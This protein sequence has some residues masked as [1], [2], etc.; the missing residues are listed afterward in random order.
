[1]PSHYKFI[2]SILISLFLIL[3]T[4]CSTIKDGPPNYHVNISKIPNAVPKPLPRSRY[5]NPTTYKVNGHRYHVLN[6]AE[7]YNKRGIASWYGSKFKGHLTSNREVYSPLAMTAASR[8]LPLP[9]FVRVTNLKNG[10]QV[11]VKVNDRGPFVANRIIDLSWAAAKKLRFA[12]KGTAL[13]QVTAI[14]PYHPNSLP[15]VRLAKHP[16]LYL[17]LG[18]FRNFANAKHLMERITKLTNRHVRINNSDYEHS[19]IYRVQIGP[20]IGV[21]ESD[22]LQNK[23]GE[24]GLGHAITVIG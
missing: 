14:N 3:L 11:I 22:E 18:A 15:P 13:V 10:R 7:G 20:L 6:S 19:P 21:G 4:A 9:T 12:G 16:K 24:L 8:N 5:G 2:I 23:L 17:Q 1:M